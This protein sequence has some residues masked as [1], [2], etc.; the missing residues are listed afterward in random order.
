M[1]GPTKD[2]SRVGEVADAPLV[3]TGAQNPGAGIAV[4]ASPFTYTAG[5]QVENVYVQAA[6]AAT[7]TV[8]KK[9]AT[10]ANMVTPAATN[11]TVS[12][13]LAPG[14]SLVVTYTVL[15]VM[16]ADRP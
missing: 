4:G 16:I 5:A 12:V 10:L 15:P 2:P 3:F 6:A 9:G 14:E 8:A 7:T 13:F 1:A 11:A